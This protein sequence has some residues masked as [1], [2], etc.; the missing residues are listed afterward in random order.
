MYATNGPRK[1][2][3]VCELL[4][5]EYLTFAD[6]HNVRWWTQRSNWLKTTGNDK[7]YNYDKNQGDVTQT[8]TLQI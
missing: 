1:N 7:P 4:I 6:E 2:E 5:F 8:F 3:P